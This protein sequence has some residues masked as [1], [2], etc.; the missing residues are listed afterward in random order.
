MSAANNIE[1][2]NDEYAKEVTEFE[3]L[4]NE[5]KEEVD[6]HPDG[7]AHTAKLSA[8]VDDKLAQIKKAKKFYGL[9][10]RL[11]KDRAQRKHY[12]EIS[13]EFD[14]RVNDASKIAKELQEK[15]NKKVL[16]G[17]AKPNENPYATEGKN[18]DELLVSTSLLY[19]FITQR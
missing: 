13:K 9:E 11:V 19:T 18:N 14:T 3:K 6:E 10:L 7:T 1:Y 15:S 4:V 12:D 8:K 17:T 2:W 16:F 5:L